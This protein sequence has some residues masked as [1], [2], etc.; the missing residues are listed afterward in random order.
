VRLGFPATAVPKSQWIIVDGDE[1][2]TNA[3]K[4]LGAGKGSLGVVEG[5]LDGC[6]DRRIS[7]Q[8]VGERRRERHGHLLI[9]SCWLQRLAN[10]GS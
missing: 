8:Q 9:V 10:E 1:R 4:R 6:I 2:D 3:R 7:Q 5:I